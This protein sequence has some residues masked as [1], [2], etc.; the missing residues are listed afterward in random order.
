MQTSRHKGLG[1]YFIILS[2]IF[3]V[4]GLAAP[5]E[6]KQTNVREATNSAV[7]VDEKQTDENAAASST[8]LE[9]KTKADVLKKIEEVPTG[10]VSPCI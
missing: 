8:A 9:N 5:I 3:G 2:V 6:K 7:P 1:L 4:I 10:K